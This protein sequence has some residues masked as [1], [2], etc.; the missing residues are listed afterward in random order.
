MP[1]KKNPNKRAPQ[2]QRARRVA[3]SELRTS[4][5]LANCKSELQK[6]AGIKKNIDLALKEASKPNPNPK[7]INN[8]IALVETVIEGIQRN[9]SNIANALRSIRRIGLPKET[10]RSIRTLEIARQTLNDIL[11]EYKS[12]L[13]RLMEIKKGF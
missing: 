13:R 4:S 2:E 5:I 11:K 6:S 8:A 7:P 1:G 10:E 9:R 12:T 3:L